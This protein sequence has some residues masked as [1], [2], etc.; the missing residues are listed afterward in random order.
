[1]HRGSFTAVVKGT[2]FAPKCTLSLSCNIF[3]NLRHHAY[4]N[5]YKISTLKN[6][7]Q[8]LLKSMKNYKSYYAMSVLPTSI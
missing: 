4:K 5:F 2:R 3:K 6:C 1:M 7:N 8:S